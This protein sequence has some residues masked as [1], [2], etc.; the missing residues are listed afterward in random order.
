MPPAAR[1]SD[2]HVCPMFDGPKPH[3]GGPVSVGMPTILIGMLPAARVGDLCVCVG[4]PDVIVKGSPTVLIDGQMAARMGDN[5][6]HGGMITVGFPTVMIGEVGMGSPVSVTDP[7]LPTPMSPSTPPPS[8][9]TADGGAGAG[10]S[11]V[12]TEDEA[13]KWMQDFKNKR[14]D[15]PLDWPRDCYY[16]RAR[17][18]SKALAAVGRTPGKVWNYAPPGEALRAN[19]SHVK[20]GYVEW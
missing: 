1:I 13:A 17:E 19:T 7:A 5:T 15:I 9:T 11:A 3:V 12:M 10:P 6:A 18:M 14:T 2:M 8:A 20:E 16:T 4:P